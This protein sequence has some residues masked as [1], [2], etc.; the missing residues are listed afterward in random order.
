MRSKM[1]IM[2]NKETKKTR[3]KLRMKIWITMKI[4]M[5]NKKVPNSLKNKPLKKTDMESKKMSQK[6]PRM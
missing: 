5:M 6:L 4:K 1:L 3:R 2:S